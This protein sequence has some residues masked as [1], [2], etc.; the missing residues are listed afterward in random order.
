MFKIDLTQNVGTHGNTTF[1]CMGLHV[2]VCIY[3]RANA[4][5]ICMRRQHLE[6]PGGGTD[7]RII[8]ARNAECTFIGG[9]SVVCVSTMSMF[10]IWHP[11]IPF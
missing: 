2:Y 11:I 3:V 5:C 7:Y 9:A 1:K 10:S 8:V 4:A 6:G